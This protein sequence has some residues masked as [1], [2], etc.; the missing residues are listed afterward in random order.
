MPFV[1]NYLKAG[2]LLGPPGG[3][4]IGP[5][6]DVKNVFFFK[7]KAGPGLKHTVGLLFLAVKKLVFLRPCFWAPT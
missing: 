3:P 6:T 4:F 5:R 7:S 1:M 2:P